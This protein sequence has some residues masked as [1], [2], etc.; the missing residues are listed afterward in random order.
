MSA[1]S[2]LLLVAPAVAGCGTQAEADA[3]LAQIETANSQIETLLP[4]GD[5]EGYVSYFTEDAF[6]ASPNSM[7][8]E[9]RAAMLAAWQGMVAIGRWSFDLETL[10]VW[11][12]SGS[13]VERGYGELSFIPGEY[14]P[15]GMGPFTAG[16]HFVAHWV[17][18]DDG[19]W[20]VRSE[21][22]ASVPAPAE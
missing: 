4:A 12:C 20:R 7:P 14:A 15:E 16:A 22:A 11:V 17:L 18:E 2:I 21:A 1:L 6:Q 10:E 19:V 9:G 13:A 3:V 8:L 5:V